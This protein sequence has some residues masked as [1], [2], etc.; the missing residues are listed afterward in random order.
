LGCGIQ[1]QDYGDLI[2][3]E[4]ADIDGFITGLDRQFDRWKKTEKSGVGKI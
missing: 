4:S 1:L 3:I 2:V